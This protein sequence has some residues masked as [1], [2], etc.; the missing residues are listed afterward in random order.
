M[1][2]PATMPSQTP[3]RPIPN[4]KAKNKVKRDVKTTVRIIVAIKEF[5]PFP[6]PWNTAEENIPK[7]V[8]G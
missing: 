6:V 2:F 3:I 4:T 5:I 7:A 1:V 8:V